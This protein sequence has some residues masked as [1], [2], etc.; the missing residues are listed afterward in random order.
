[1][2]S[3]GN[4][5]R[6]NRKSKGLLLRQL[7]AVLDID[8]AVLSKIERGERT[9]SKL[10]IE[11]IAKALKMDANVLIENQLIDKILFELSD[12]ENPLEI[13]IKVNKEL[14]SKK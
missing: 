10:Q 4:V 5:I 6:E 3:V 9:P 8:V 13:L 12:F 14:K 7:A 2:N 1:M 11:K